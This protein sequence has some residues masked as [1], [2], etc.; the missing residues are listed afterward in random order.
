METISDAIA[1]ISDPEFGTPNPTNQMAAN[2]AVR[3]SIEF[4]I[5][6]YRDRNVLEVNAF[7]VQTAT[8]P[9]VAYLANI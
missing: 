1:A 7:R 5:R 2:D 4:G 9:T 6:C 3:R 8:F